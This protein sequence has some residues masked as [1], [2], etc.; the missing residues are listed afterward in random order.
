VIRVTIYHLDASGEDTVAGAITWDGRQL[1]AD[2]P[3][4][5]A[6]RRIIDEPIG[7]QVEGGGAG[8]VRIVTPDEDPEAWLRN[9]YRGYRSIA[10][11]ASRP[12]ESDG[13]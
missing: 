12:I 6:L 10:L 2:P 4:D 1:A 9:L 13:A 11:R 8:G 5:P 3:G 7:V